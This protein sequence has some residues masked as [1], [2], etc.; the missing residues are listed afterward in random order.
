MSKVT[1]ETCLLRLLAYVLGSLPKNPPVIALLIAMIM[2][3]HVHRCTAAS[4]GG[5]SYRNFNNRG[6][7]DY[8]AN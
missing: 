7:S 2:D 3:E 8:L 4:V 6:A 5:A 1:M